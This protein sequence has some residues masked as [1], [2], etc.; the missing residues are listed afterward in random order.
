MV[1]EAISRSGRDGCIAA[2]LLSQFS[3]LPYSSVTARFCALERKGLIVRGPDKRQGPSGRAQFVMRIAEYA[4]P[5]ME[6]A[7]L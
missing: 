1:H 5:A 2:D 4:G 6:T 3:Y 7:S